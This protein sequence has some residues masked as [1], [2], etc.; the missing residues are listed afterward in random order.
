M[1]NQST[2][3]N[4]IWMR[5]LLAAC[6]LSCGI[7]GAQG[8]AAELQTVRFDFGDKPTAGSWN[9]V[10]DP[11][12]AGLRVQGAV[13]LAGV[14]TSVA[15][16]QTDGWAGFNTDGAR[17]AEDAP[18]EKTDRAPAT[19]TGDSFYLE[20][21]VD[22]LAR[23]ELEGLQPGEKYTLALFASRMAANDASQRVALFT[24]GEQQVRLD[25]SN[26]QDR[27]AELKEVVADDRGV[28][29]LQIECPAGQDYAYLNVLEIRGVFGAAADYRLPPEDLTGPPLTTARAWAIA[30]GATGDLLWGEQESAVRQMASTTK[31][32]TAWIVLELA[33]KNPQLLEEI[34]TISAR[35][36]KT[37]GSTAGVRVGEKLPVADLLFGL[38]LPSGNDAAVALAEHVGGRLPPPSSDSEPGAKEQEPDDLARFVAEMNRRAADLGMQ[39]THYFDPHGNSPNRSSARDLIRLA[40]RAMQYERFRQYVSTREYRCQLQHE[41]TTREAVWKNT[42][43]LLQFGGYDGIKT[44]TTGGAGACLVSRGQRGDDVLLVVVLGSTSSDARYVDSRN[45]YRWAWRERQPL[46]GE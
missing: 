36:D 27:W 8:G 14:A 3:A 13:D 42:N 7:G 30:D 34:V 40:F 26:N 46:A 15:L 12:G 28:I 6:I 39:E 21:G 32:M 9:A 20:A 18:E 45:L 5:R 23:L 38:L 41:D 17:P 16:R 1:R 43:Q 19:A 11:R 22:A 31:M 2:I 25:A 33:G 24:A 44:G 10:D 37:G 35:A 29:G 4:A